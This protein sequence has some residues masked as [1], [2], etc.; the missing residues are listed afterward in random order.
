VTARLRAIG[1]G[2]AVLEARARLRQAEAD[3]LE[4]LRKQAAVTP[5]P[6]EMDVRA[7]RRR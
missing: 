6:V 3:L 1:L 5:R 4:D 2:L 7:R